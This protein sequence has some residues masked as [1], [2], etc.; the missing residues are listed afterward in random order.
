MTQQEILDAAMR[1]SAVDC[2]CSAEDFRRETNVVVE[3]RPSA[4]ASRYLTNPNICALFTY[5][6][7]VVASCRGD[8]RRR[9]D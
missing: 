6:S 4:D 7:N 8:G 2:S 5:G 9:A 3:S 1:Q